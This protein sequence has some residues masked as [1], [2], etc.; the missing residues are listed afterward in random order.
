[1]A[2]KTSQWLLAS[3][4][5]ASSALDR[6]SRFM[7]IANYAAAAVLLL[8]IVLTFVD[9]LLR[10]FFN[11]PIAGSVELVQFGMIILVF[12]GGAYCQLTKAHVG[13]DLVVTALSKKGQVV[14]NSITYFLYL[15]IL[16]LIVI[17]TTLDS[18]WIAQ[19]GQL[20][21]TLLLPIAPVKF[22]IPFGCLLLL[23]VVSRDFLNYLIEGIKLQLGKRLWFLLLG[24]IILLVSVM[25]VW[26]SP[27]LWELNSVQA[28]LLG[29][30]VMI[31]FL[32]TG[33]P[34]A[35]VM[36]LIGFLGLARVSGLDAGFHMV[37]S[38]YYE[39]VGTYSWSAIPFFVLMG[40]FCYFATFSED[41]YKSIYRWIGHFRGGLAMSTLAAC[42]LFSAVVG[43]VLSSTLSMGAVSLP[44]MR[45]Y[46]YSDELA[47]GV[48]AAG[49]TLGP[50]IPPSV[51][52][53]IYAVLADQSIGKL[54][55]A[56]II[57]GVLLALIWMIQIYIQ[58]RI[59]PLMG[60]PGERATWS[61][62]FSS[63]NAI[64]PIVVL[65]LLV[66]GGIY[67][68]LFTATEAG[69][70]GSFGALLIGIVMKR[71]TLKKIVSALV[72]SV[73]VSS[74]S[75]FIL[76]SAMIFSYFV[77]SST[78]PIE[79]SNIVT[80]LKMAPI[81]LIAAIL[82]VLL[83]LGCFMPSLPMI[84]LTVPIFL[85]MI[86]SYGF[87]LIWFGVLMVVMMNIACIT[88]P[89]GINLFVLTAV[90]KNLPL[91]VVYR[92]VIPFCITNLIFVTILVPFPFIATWL[93]RVLGK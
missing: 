5:T 64:G 45:R 89:Y 17:H 32:F 16:V 13:V 39:T 18:F 57:P 74:M 56:G 12:L 36:V 42:T 10:Y 4:E 22:I 80:S 78:L 53:I 60:P 23:I 30:I 19:E 90:S 76:G 68:G 14:L 54:F 75:F 69:A 34:V 67:F 87:D 40:F 1:M 85:P 6:T 79:L 59:N 55:I 46:K 15:G 62:R 24:I 58:C 37:G 51:G 44:E 50:L 66:I 38:T 70:I 20:T 73:K 86:S 52:F 48:I 41:L 8:I 28:G 11:K 7:S 93:P 82:I 26:A 27:N 71:F 21:R 2:R 83:I 9:V 91:S 25:W 47:S 33:M 61:A 63:L 72:E 65:F 77:A 81:A 49:G 29:M 3:L 84:M 88:P 31:V 43:D 35:F 92:G